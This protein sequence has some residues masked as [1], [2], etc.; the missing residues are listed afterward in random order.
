MNGLTVQRIETGLEPGLEPYR[1]LK[2]TA[3]QQRDRM[4]IAQG[5]VAV[6]ALLRSSYPILSLLTDEVWLENLRP[7]WATRA[8]HFTAF[9]GDALLVERLIGHRMH[10][11]V[12]AAGRIPAMPTLDALLND[13]H[14]SAVGPRLW[15]AVDGLANAENLGAIVRNAVAFEAEAL[16]VG[17]TSASPFLRRAVRS[18]MGAVFS[19]P[20][21]EIGSLVH[22]LKT[23]ANQGFRIIGAESGPG[24]VKI[25]DAD[26][27]GD[28]CVV[29]GSEG[30]GLSEAVRQVCHQTV[31]IPTS[32]SVTSLNVASASAVF[33]HEIRRRRQHCD[34]CIA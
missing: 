4:V 25:T 15:I 17:E 3:D 19:L 33:L 7:L 9:V 27:A 2:R 6:R 8:D 32:S 29:F 21:L 26:F 1:T 23:A 14:A 24:H 12:M 16:L 5:P 30:G 31:A 34:D 28:L 11:S 20:V 22:G 10:Q 13:V 18:S